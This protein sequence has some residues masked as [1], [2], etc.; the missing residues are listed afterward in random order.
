MT[1]PFEGLFITENKLIDAIEDY[2]NKY[3]FKLMKKAKNNERG[4]DL[5]LSKNGATLYIEAKGSVKNKYDTD[6]SIGAM[7]K[8]SVRDNVKSQINKLMERED[9]KKYKNN[10][11]YIAAWPETPLYR[12]QVNKKSKALSRLGYLHLWVQED[13]SIKIEGPNSEKL[14]NLCSVQ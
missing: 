11:F 5:E 13:L 14:N 12:E 7:P 4:I 1:K 10:A 8:S 3:D 9:D 6:N 2:F